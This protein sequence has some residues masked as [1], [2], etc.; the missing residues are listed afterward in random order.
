MSTK[1]SEA[2]F[3]LLFLWQPKIRQVVK[4]E[5]NVWADQGV[6]FIKSMTACFVE[7][8]RLGLG[9]PFDPL[10]VATFTCKVLGRDDET[11]VVF[12]S[13]KSHGALDPEPSRQETLGLE[14]VGL[15][16][17]T[18]CGYLGGSLS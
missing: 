1:E 3:N 10:R 15:I 8:G 13:L 6:F 12:V 11:K 16:S 5:K 9:A 14:E 2:G 7:H 18:T 17:R 4:W